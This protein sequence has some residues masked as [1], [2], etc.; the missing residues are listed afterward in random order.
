MKITWI[1]RRAFERRMR[2]AGQTFRKE[3]RKQFRK[4][5]NAVR[6]AVRREIRSTLRGGTGCA[7]RHTR[8]RV[9]VSRNRAWAVVYPAG[10]SRAYM[11]IQEWGGTVKRKGKLLKTRLEHSRRGARSRRGK[12]NVAK[13]TAQPTYRPA[14]Q[15][16][17]AEVFRLLGRSFRV[18]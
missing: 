4:A 14:V 13:Y 3:M 7:A 6:R 1:G 8:V 2:R 18:V 10:R 12:P 5:A 15:K 11:G 17:S 16:S 9:R